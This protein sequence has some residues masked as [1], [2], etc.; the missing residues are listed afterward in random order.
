MAARLLLAFVAATSGLRPMDPPPPERL[1]LTSAL[2]NPL[3]PA[4][5][6]K[7]FSKPMGI[8]EEGIAAALEVM[9]SGRLS[10][11]CATSAATSEVARA[12]TEF[13]EVARSRYA[14][15]TNSGS[16]A[17]MLAL[18]AVGVT[19]GDRV[20]CSGFGFSPLPSTI[21]RLGA[22]PVLVDAT[23]DWAMDLD[24]LEAAADGAPEARVVLLAHARGQVADMD[25]V[26]ALCDARG[27]FLV[28]D[29]THALGVCWRGRPVGY[30]GA[31]AAFS[32][33]SDSVLNGGEG[34]FVTTDDDDRAARLMFLGGC[35][36]RRYGKHASRPSDAACEQAMATMPNLS[37]RMSEVTAA[38]LRPLI[39]SLPERLARHRRRYASVLD[40]LAARAPAIAVPQ[41]DARAD[42]VGDA[43]F[44]GLPSVD[45]SQN[46]LFRT[47]CVAMGVP[48]SWFGSPVN[49]RHH[50]NARKYGCPSFDLPAADAL[51]ARGYE[52]RLPE[53]FEDG[54]FPQIARI[55]A[56]AATVAAEA[57]DDP[58]D[59]GINLL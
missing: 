30:H 31:A 57:Y 8:P 5:F 50:A 29:A 37:V 18:M 6:G 36:E 52:L 2:A 9:R 40:V 17:L 7:D 11:Y 20:L 46:A 21:M 3:A 45:D 38:L 42:P 13:A 41:P 27:L 19:P 34:G 43:L 56:Y 39:R 24:A 53:H 59:D 16:S 47:T 33:R 25:R 15:A 58:H 12:E 55:L 48:V 4:R 23:E 49:A 10:R 14:I 32:C 1:S 28:E 54:D 44:F 35:S 26:A 22:E 51:L